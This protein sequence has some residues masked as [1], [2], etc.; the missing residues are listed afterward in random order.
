MF[1][2]FDFTDLVKAEV[3]LQGNRASSL[4]LARTLKLFVLEDLR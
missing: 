2:K 1:D 3:P 4:Q